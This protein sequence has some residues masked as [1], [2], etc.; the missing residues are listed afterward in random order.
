MNKIEGMSLFYL[1]SINYGTFY[2]KKHTKCFDVKFSVKIS[3]KCER[4]KR[5]KM[6]RTLRKRKRKSCVKSTN[7]TL[8]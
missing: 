2:M 3:T 5:K 1:S 6:G 4:K 7:Q 8:W